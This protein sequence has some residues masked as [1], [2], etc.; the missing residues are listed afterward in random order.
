M[1]SIL[2]HKEYY[3]VFSTCAVIFFLIWAGFY[4][5]NYYGLEV[6]GAYKRYSYLAVE[7]IFVISAILHYSKMGK[8]RLEELETE[9]PVTK[10]KIV[11]PKV[12]DNPFK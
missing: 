11:R 1:R 7:L 12:N 6:P 3:H 10:K 4:G 2:S 9:Y 5:I 8:E